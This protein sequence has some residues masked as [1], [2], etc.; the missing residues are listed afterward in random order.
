MFALHSIYFMQQ[1]HFVAAVKSAWMWQLQQHHHSGSSS[2][3]QHEESQVK[4]VTSIKIHLRCFHVPIK[5]EGC[6]LQ[7]SLHKIQSNTIPSLTTTLCTLLWQH[8]QLHKNRFMVLYW[9]TLDCIQVCIFLVSSGIS[10]L[11]FYYL[12]PNNILNKIE[13]KSFTKSIKAT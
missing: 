6:V 7:A 8:Y 9:I 2:Y 3:L 13:K 4:F 5:E 10:F 12:I 1:V 11:V